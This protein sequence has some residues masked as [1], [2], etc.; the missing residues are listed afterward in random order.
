MARNEKKSARP[1]EHEVTAE[2]L[3]EQVLELPSREAFSVV[4]S[5]PTFL[6]AGGVVEE[7]VPDELPAEALPPGSGQ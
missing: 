3:E 5:S 4:L 6:Q 7:V 2:E 1:D